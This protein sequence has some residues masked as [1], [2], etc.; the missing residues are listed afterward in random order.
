MSEQIDVAVDLG[1]VAPSLPDIVF[2]REFVAQLEREYGGTEEW[3]ALRAAV[4]G[5]KP[6]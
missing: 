4:E 5:R 6:S 1:A 3:Q 2:L